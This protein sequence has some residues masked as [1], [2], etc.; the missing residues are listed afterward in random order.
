VE[1]SQ[2]EPRSEVVCAA[3]ARAG[4]M[5]KLFGEAQN[6]VR[7][8]QTLDIALFTLLEFGFALIDCDCGL[9]LPS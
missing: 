2:L 1:W 6:I 9:I 3:E 8:C 7:R 5:L 4:E